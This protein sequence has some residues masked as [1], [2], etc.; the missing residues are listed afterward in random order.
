MI[1]RHRALALLTECTGDTIWPVDHCQTR[2]IPPSWIDELS[3]AFESGFDEDRNTIY[4]NEIDFANRQGTNQFHGVRDIDLAIKIG[5]SIGIDVE[6]LQST[7]LGRS[8][9]VAAIK[10]AVME[11]D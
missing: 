7:T 3:G 2:G 4:L 6:R 9:L 1:S 11:G 10:E 8:A 5:H